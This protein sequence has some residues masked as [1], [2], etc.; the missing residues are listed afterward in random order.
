M[1]AM[2]VVRTMRGL[3]NSMAALASGA[4]MM[5]KSSRAAAAAIEE[6]AANNRELARCRFLTMTYVPKERQ[7]TTAAKDID[8]ASGMPDNDPGMAFGYLS[9]IERMAGFPEA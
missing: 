4:V 7:T 5:R 1:A 2:T 3:A 6:R 8:A 9:H